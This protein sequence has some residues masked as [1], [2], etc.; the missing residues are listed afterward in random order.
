MRIKCIVSYDGTNFYGFQRQIKTRTVQGEIESALKTIHNKCITIHGSGRTDA[1]VHAINQVFHFDSNLN[2]LAQNWK[3]AINSLVPKDI[4]IK[5]VQIVDED[6]H[7][8]FSA[9]KKEYHY[10]MFLGDYDPHN[11][12]YYY[13]PTYK[14]NLDNMIEGSKY[15]I[16]THDFTSF[17][18]NKED[19]NKVKT[20][21]SIDFIRKG[22]EVVIKFLGT[23]FLRYMV[24]I[25]TGTL[26]DVGRGK[27]NPEEIKE[28]L[29]QKN[30]LKTG[31]L[32]EPQ[33]LYLFMV[34]Y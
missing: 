22:D 6:F 13:F 11:C 33:G 28:I 1:G 23:G 9:K 12:N 29:E 10:K 30:R 17:C 2:L 4:Y 31:T 3:K 15:L 27:R 16:G 18:A 21:E 24:R 32:A 26:I 5:D 19:K 25:I 8:R 20:I 14:L 7:S 34:Y